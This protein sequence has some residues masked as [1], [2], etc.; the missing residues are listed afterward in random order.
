VQAAISHYE[1]VFQEKEELVLAIMDHFHTA[2]VDIQQ[3]YESNAYEQESYSISF[4]FVVNG[5]TYS[6]TYEFDGIERCIRR[7][8][9]DFVTSVE[10][11]V[12]LDYGRY[13]SENTIFVDGVD[14]RDVARRAKRLK[15]EIIQ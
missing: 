7:L 5:K 4:S 13:D 14:L 10:G 6:G 15:V 1:T 8:E 9:G 12:E 11:V 2:T 3:I